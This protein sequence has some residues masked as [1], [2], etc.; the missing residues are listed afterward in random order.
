MNRKQRR[1]LAIGVLLMAL[2]FIFP[3][4]SLEGW[5]I[6]R[7]PHFTPFW[8]P[9]TWYD[10]PD[11]SVLRYDLIFNQLQLLAVLTFWAIL[12][13][14][15][16]LDARRRVI[17]RAGLASVGLLLLPKLFFVWFLFAGIGRFDHIPTSVAIVTIIGLL[18]PPRGGRGYWPRLP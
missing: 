3:P 11:I 17:H 18:L 9:P 1:A 13:C 8:S 2:T 4:Y 14:G 7:G 16:R 6:R 5:L 10:E 12:V 15:S